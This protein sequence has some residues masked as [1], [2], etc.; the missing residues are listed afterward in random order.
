MEK[1]NQEQIFKKIW[2]FNKKRSFGSWLKKIS[3]YQFSDEDGYIWF[4]DEYL[5]EFKE[6]YYEF[7]M[8]LGDNKS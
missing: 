5:C 2:N 6:E 4:A 7:I 8:S 1:L 3:E